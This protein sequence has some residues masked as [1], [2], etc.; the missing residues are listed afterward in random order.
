MHPSAIT[1]A[2]K[3]VTKY[4]DPDKELLI[5]DIG[6]FNVNG[7]LKP[8]FT[9]DGLTCDYCGNVKPLP[10]VSPFQRLG[11]EYAADRDM[12]EV[13]CRAWDCH[14]TSPMKHLW[15][16]DGE[17]FR[18]MTLTN[19]QIGEN[20]D[21]HGIET[22]SAIEP[23]GPLIGTEEGKR[24]NVTT[25]IDDP[26][27]YPWPE[28]HIDV[29]VSTS[30]LEHDDLFWVTFKE[31]VRVVKPG[32]F[33]YLN[34]PSAGPYHGYPLDCW[35]FQA[36]AYTALSRWCPEVELVE[37]WVDEKTGWNDNIGIFKIRE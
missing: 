18:P 32:G 9:K 11:V 36:D 7:C 14:S 12:P 8:L 10:K 4:L 21:Y 15:C 5:V 17:K 28:N 2:E 35:R 16:C 33:I 23:Y 34:V 30:C 20:W 19:D 3:F 31:M 13:W 6:S 24:Y 37:S 25:V 1:N 26:H 27:V 22:R 29:I